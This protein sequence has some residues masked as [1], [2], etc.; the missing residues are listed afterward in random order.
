MTHDP[1]NA[2]LGLGVFLAFLFT[3]AA[4]GVILRARWSG[5]SAG[6]FV[7]LAPLW[8]FAIL[9]TAFCSGM[10]SHWLGSKILGGVESVPGWELLACAACAALLVMIGDYLAVCLRSKRMVRW[11]DFV[12]TVAS[13]PLF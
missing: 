4:G 8:L 10:A 5:L 2:A 7:V 11:S 3:L 1:I 13:A 12:K 6:R 9:L